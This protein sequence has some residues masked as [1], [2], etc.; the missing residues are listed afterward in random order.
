MTTTISSPKGEGTIHVHSYSPIGP[1]PGGGGG[2]V[3]EM[4]PPRS[5]YKTS[6]KLAIRQEVSTRRSGEHGTHALTALG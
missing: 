6:L 1:H 5:S 2:H 3:P 4:L